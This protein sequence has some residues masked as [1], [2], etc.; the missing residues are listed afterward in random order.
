MCVRPSVNCQDE[1][2]AQ[3]PELG[4]DAAATASPRHVTLWTELR[5]DGSAQAGCIAASHGS[6]HIDRIAVPTTCGVGLAKN[7][8]PLSIK[9][10]HEPAADAREKRS[11]FY[12]NEWQVS[13]SE[14]CH[15]NVC[16]WVI[17]LK[18]AVLQ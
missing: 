14:R 3:R 10:S 16:F 15:L 9:T 12:M 4:P 5:A 1:L 18:K 11:C 8:T 13:G 6:D 2:D 17:V 7:L